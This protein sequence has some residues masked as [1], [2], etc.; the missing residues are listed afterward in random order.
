MRV[1][2]CVCCVWVCVSA[3]V[4]QRA[5]MCMHARA[6]TH[7]LCT[8]LVYMQLRNAGCRGLILL[9]IGTKVVHETDARIAAIV[10]RCALVARCVG[11][12]I[13]TCTKRP[14]SSGVHRKRDLPGVSKN[15]VA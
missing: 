3:W 11:Q 5:R 10:A 14:C 15:R 9:M 6:H 2:V 1:R 8:R 13:I 12:V 7:V 4:R